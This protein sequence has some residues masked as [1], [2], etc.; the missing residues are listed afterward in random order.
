MRK[1]TLFATLILSITINVICI[2]PYAGDYFSRLKN[3]IYPPLYFDEQTLDSEVVNLVIDA[4]MKMDGS[5]FNISQPKRGLAHDIKQFISFESSTERT[6]NFSKSFLYAGLSEWAYKKKDTKVLEYLERQ[7]AD[8]SDVGKLNYM[9]EEV[10]QVPIGLCYINLYKITK[11]KDYLDCAN[12]IYNW[13]LT[14]REKDTNIIYYKKD[15]PNQYVD[16]LGMYVP[17]LVEYSKLTGDTFAHSIA[18]ENMLE[19]YKYGVDKETGIPSHGYN[20]KTGIKVGSLNWGRGIGW[21]LLAASY[22]PDFTEVNMKQKLHL[23]SNTQFPQTSRNFD[24]SVALLFEI[25]M[26]SQGLHSKSIDFIKPYILQSGFVTECSGD[27]YN[28]NNYSNNFS[29]AELTNGF[30]LMLVAQY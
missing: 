12:S 26:Q 22:L 1:I 19:F 25:Y 24:S 16:G 29:S 9:L 15:N 7:V 17:F 28:F 5:H 21:Y 6:N 20:L 8:F 30:F 11:N 27:T 2:M 13:L 23:I 14:R 18:Y 10:D 4:S 3:Y